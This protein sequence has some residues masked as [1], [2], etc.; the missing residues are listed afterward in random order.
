MGAGVTLKGKVAIVTGGNTGIGKAVVLGLAAEG[1]SIVIDYV[2]DP[3]A[4]EA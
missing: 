1:A 2:S 3:D 4:A